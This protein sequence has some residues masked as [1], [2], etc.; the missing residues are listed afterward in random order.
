MSS[1]QSTAPA[2]ALPPAARSRRAYDPPAMATTT[3][4][5]SA[6]CAGTI[7]NT[8]RRER[9]GGW[10]RRDTTERRVNEGAMMMRNISAMSDRPRAAALPVNCEKVRLYKGSD[11]IR[12][13]FT[14]HVR[15]PPSVWANSQRQ[16]H[17][18]MAKLAPCIPSTT[19][20]THDSP[21]ALRATLT[22]DS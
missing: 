4:L 20:V 13:S 16:P 8:R 12:P 18:E 1:S 7:R 22:S 9:G 19:G 11:E 5:P 10:P 21:R 2:D 15:L 17:L 3:L 14:V 6:R